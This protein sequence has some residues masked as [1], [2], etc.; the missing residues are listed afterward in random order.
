MN[1]RTEVWEG[2]EFTF[3]CT[4]Y[5]SPDIVFTWYKDGVKINFNGT[6]RLVKCNKLIHFERSRGLR[7]VSKVPIGI[8]CFVLSSLFYDDNSKLFMN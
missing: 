5:G 6:T 7:S 2:S 1:L 3:S 4:A 8:D